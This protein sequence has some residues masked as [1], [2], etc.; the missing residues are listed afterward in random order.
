MI[1]SGF[2]LGSLPWCLPYLL[3]AAGQGTLLATAAGCLTRVR[4]LACFGAFDRIWTKWWWV[5]RLLDGVAKRTFRVIA[6]LPRN[7]GILAMSAVVH[8]LT[9]LAVWLLARAIA[10]PSSLGRRSASSRRSCRSR[11]FRFRSVGERRETA[12][13]NAFALAEL[14]QAGGPR[15]RRCSAAH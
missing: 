2:V 7:I 11:L 6:T 10:M 4:R 5:T 1:L 3:N 15:Y 12:M 9:V 14:S 13:M 8:V